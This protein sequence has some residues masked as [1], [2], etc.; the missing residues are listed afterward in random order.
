MDNLEDKINSLFSSPESLAQIKK[1]AEALSG[2][3][4]GSSSSPA[5]AAGIP[6]E[7]FKAPETPAS[8]SSGKAPAFD[9]KLMQLFASVMREYSAPS[10]A[11]GLINAL[12][13]YLKADRL[14]RV[15]KAM[16]IAKLAKAAKAIL[17]ELGGKGLV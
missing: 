2:S 16:S 6:S 4:L 9:P 1:L 14:A 12:R 7:P 3:G 15:D 11:S 5:E 10:E 13:P 17:P 8:A